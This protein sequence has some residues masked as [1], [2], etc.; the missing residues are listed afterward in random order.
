MLKAKISC[1]QFA[2]LTVTFLLDTGAAVTIVPPQLLPRHARIQHDTVPA[3]QSISGTP[4]RVHGTL[5]LVIAIK[6][7]RREFNW[8][9]VVADVEYAVIGADFLRHYRLSVS[10][11][12]S[13]IHDDQTNLRF[14]LQSV[15]AALQSPT[16][17]AAA[18]L[19][20]DIANI[21][22]SFPT[23]TAPQSTTSTDDSQLSLFHIETVGNPVAQ[24][25]RRLNP[26][27]LAVAKSY[28]EEL[29]RSGIVENSSSEW[30]SP[31]HMVPKKSGDWRPCGDYR[32]L[33]RQ[34]IKDQYPLPH[35]RDLT[36]VFAGSRIY[37]KLDL[38]RAYHHI[39][40]APAD[41][42]K[43][44][45][46]TPFGLFQYRKMPFGLK[47]SAQ[48]FQRYMDAV[49]RSLS[50]LQSSPFCVCYVDDLLIFSADRATHIQHLRQVFEVLER[51]KL[52]IN[53]TKCSFAQSTIEFLGHQIDENGVRPSPEKVRAL[54]NMPS[55]GTYDELRSRVGAI[56]Y[57]RAFVPRCAE[58]LEPLHKLLAASKPTVRRSRRQITT[59]ATASTR[60]LQ[61]SVLHESSYRAVLATLQS[62]IL[63][64]PPQNLSRV[65]LTTDASDCAIGAV[66]HAADSL[67]PL[68]FY[69]R[70]LTNSERHR[71][72]FDR[73]LLALCC[74]ARHF[75]H[76]TESVHTVAITDHR[77]LVAALDSRTSESHNR[78]QQ[79]RLAVISELVDEI[80]FVPGRDNIVADALS[81]ICATPAPVATDLPAIAEHQQSDHQLPDLIRE[82]SLVSVNMGK[83]LELYCYVTGPQ[84]R[85]YV[86][87]TL[88]IPLIQQTHQLAHPGIRATQALVL[89]THWW[90]NAKTDIRDFV[91]SCLPCQQSKITTHT[92][93]SPAPMP[94]ASRRFEIVHLDIV[95]PLPVADLRYRYLLTLVDRFSS[96]PVAEPLE[97]ITAETVAR[98]LIRCWISHYGVPY[99]IITDRGRQFTSALFT[100]IARR[101]G[102]ASVRTSAYRPQAN[103]K[104]E[105]F[106]RRLKDA[107]R[108][109]QSDWLAD[110]PLVLWT[111]RFTTPRNAEF[112]PFTLLTGESASFPAAVTD[113]CSID[114]P[115]EL[116]TRLRQLID[117]A[118]ASTFD[119]A[120]I[121]PPAIPP[122]LQDADEVWVRI[123]RVRRPLEAPYSG[124]FRVIDRQP[125]YFVI[126]TPRGRTTVSVHRLKPVVR[127]VPTNTTPSTRTDLPRTDCHTY[128]TRSGR[129][130]RF[131]T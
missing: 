68:G 34:T 62:A 37:T 100:N 98:S 41:R 64:H 126:D 45:I 76:F 26:D 19:P 50:H 16:L 93:A 25:P 79:S 52:H 13:T 49:L 102:F 110:L 124:P 128:T 21:L 120:I 40:V 97:D 35:I 115:L 48:A 29:L 58:T 104:V 131:R 63:A 75:R 10:C 47:N 57:Y 60:S 77:P 36:S 118:S 122:S 46:T 80:R 107:L 27:K 119:T 43:T 82:H 127:S 90:P 9:A 108:A 28:F 11:H 56:N 94:V 1:N 61:W 32:L 17:N 113:R 53:L 112:S 73:E 106:H 5:P 105:R 42:P 39:T 15:S 22:Q 91:R 14:P 95:G 84:P 89:S 114:D 129:Q 51:H 3:L 8:T 117:T 116:V 88:R 123:D 87:P 69:S 96:W 81:R 103:G 31:L 121:E 85:P 109:R 54:C 6:S 78:W 7:I 72:A 18:N 24:R 59:S 92:Q 12:D 20:S 130:V 55:P 86:P 101:L 74:G 70:R 4:I 111:F 125:R 23:V 30:A 66:L 71:S 83:D 44:A 65:T 33:N 2:P 38:T 67:T 99:Q